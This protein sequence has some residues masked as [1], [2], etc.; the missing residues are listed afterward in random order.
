METVSPHFLARLDLPSNC[1]I[2]SFI[3][4]LRI[5]LINLLKP[6]TLAPREK[7]KFGID[8]AV[9][10]HP[11]ELLFRAQGERS[12]AREQKREVVMY[13][14]LKESGQIT[15]YAA[16]KGTMPGDGGYSL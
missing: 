9:G 6:E 13:D 15:V 4:D 8:F 5:V 14:F 7:L 12:G 11:T 3:T 10:C 2:L 1:L 16:T